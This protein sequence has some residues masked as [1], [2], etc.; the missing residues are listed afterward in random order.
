MGG[1]ATKGEGKDAKNGGREREVKRK[2]GKRERD[3]RG[4][5]KGRR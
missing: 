4:V 2:K 3:G 1:G 5:R